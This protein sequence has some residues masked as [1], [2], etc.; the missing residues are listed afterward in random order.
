MFGVVLHRQ[1]NANR[2]SALFS[3]IGS[4]VWQPMIRPYPDDKDADTRS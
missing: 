2:P 3:C 4:F 1:H